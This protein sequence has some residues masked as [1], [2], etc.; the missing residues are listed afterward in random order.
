MT[1]FAVAPLAREVEISG[2]TLLAVC[3]GEVQADQLRLIKPFL[4]AA[5]ESRNPPN[6]TFDQLHICTAYRK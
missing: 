5:K 4:L 1:V 6:Q 2:H 3:L